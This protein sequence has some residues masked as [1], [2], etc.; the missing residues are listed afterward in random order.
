MLL[1]RSAMEPIDIVD[2]K[3]AAQAPLESWHR[4]VDG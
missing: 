4:A 2:L 3:A 1:A